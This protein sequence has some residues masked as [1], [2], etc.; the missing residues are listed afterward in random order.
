LKADAELDFVGSV[1]ASVTAAEPGF[2]TLVNR[3]LQS[4]MMEGFTL[5]VI[6]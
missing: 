6:D 2:P 3:L 4:L 5:A 1:E